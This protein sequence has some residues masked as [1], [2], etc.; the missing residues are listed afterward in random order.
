LRAIIRADSSDELGH[1]HV[2]RGL[3][4]AE[5]L[6]AHGIDARLASRPLR[7]ALAGK[8][9]VA[10]RT[11]WLSA[12]ADALQDAPAD[13]DETLSACTKHG[14]TPDIAVVDHYGLGPEW[15]ERAIRRGLLVVA[16]DDYPDRRHAADLVFDF[17]GRADDSDATRLGGLR[18][19]PIDP[20]FAGPPAHPMPLPPWRIALFFGS[21]DLTGQ[22]SVAFEALRRLATMGRLEVAH[23]HVVAGAESAARQ[24]LA[25]SVSGL[26]V[27]RLSIQ[28]PSL[29]PVLANADAFLTAAGNSMLEALALGLPT[30]TVETAE[31]QRGLV[32]RLARQP[33]ILHL[34]NSA[35]VGAAEWEAGVLALRERFNSTILPVLASRPIDGRGAERIAERIV[36]LASTNRARAIGG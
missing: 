17:S 20:R 36:A 14:F 2:T 8:P 25:K 31:N 4:L 3:V 34:G 24:Q 1:G 9:G 7:G 22:T 6:R 26:P 23:I 16:L 10:D 35:D 28:L 19:V 15:E 5:A 33:C 21:S 29:L 13:F 32:E 30:V 11:I 27:A 18:Y 12:A